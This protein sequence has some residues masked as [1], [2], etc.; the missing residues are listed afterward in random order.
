MDIFIPMY[1]ETLL[2]AILLAGENAK[3]APFV[4]AICLDT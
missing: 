1:P 4:D 3:L 2:R